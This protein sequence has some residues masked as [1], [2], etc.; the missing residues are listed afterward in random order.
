LGDSF[1]FGSSVKRE[2]NYPATLTRLLNNGKICPANVSFEVI[3][4]GVYG[5][6][7]NYALERFKM[8]GLKYRPDLVIWLINDWN[9]TSYKEY[10]LPR[11]EQLR[12]EKGSKDYIDEIN[13]INYINVEIK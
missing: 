3:N 10:F 8:R 1:T 5:Y 13:L 9:F 6:D 12:S 2:K 7:L 4:L 11:S